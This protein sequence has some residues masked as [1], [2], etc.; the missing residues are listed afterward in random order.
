KG[1]LQWVTASRQW[2]LRPEE[3]SP[4]SEF[5]FDKLASPDDPYVV[6]L[7]SRLRQEGCSPWWVPQDAVREFLAQGGEIVYDEDG[8][9]LR[10]RHH[11]SEWILL[12]RRD[13]PMPSPPL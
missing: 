3:P 11:S 7:V 8:R 9:Y 5:G 10:T 4:E 1:R 12:G 13:A 2:V 6:D